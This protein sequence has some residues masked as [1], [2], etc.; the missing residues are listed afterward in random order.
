[1]FSAVW[2]RI[3]PMR[4]HF[5]IAVEPYGWARDSYIAQGAT[6][7]W[8]DGVRYHFEITLRPGIDCD[9]SGKTASG[10]FGGVGVRMYASPATQAVY[11]EYVDMTFHHIPK[12]IENSS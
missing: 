5:Q 2:V 6:S 1:M 10:M 7:V 12:P 9:S 8:I 11:Y 3:P 4:A